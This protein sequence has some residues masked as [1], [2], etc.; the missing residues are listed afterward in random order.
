MRSRGTSKNACRG[1]TTGLPSARLA[2]IDSSQPTLSPGGGRA[3]YC[4]PLRQHWNSYT[5]CGAAE[6]FG[7]V[8][9]RVMSCWVERSTQRVDRLCTNTRRSE[10]ERSTEDTCWLA[11]CCRPL[12]LLEWAM[13]A[14]KAAPVKAGLA[15]SWRA[16]LMCRPP[17]CSISVGVCC[18]SATSSTMSSSAGQPSHSAHSSGTRGCTKVMSVVSILPSSLLLLLLPPLLWPLPPPS[19]PPPMECR[20]AVWG[21]TRRPNASSTTSRPAARAS[22]TALAA[23][24]VCCACCAWPHS[25]DSTRTTAVRWF[26][27]RGALLVEQRSSHRQLISHCTSGVSAAP[28]A[29]SSLPLWAA[30]PPASAPLAQA[31]T[32]NANGARSSFRRVNKQL[33]RTRRVAFATGIKGTGLSCASWLGDSPSR[34]RWSKMTQ[35]A[36]SMVSGPAVSLL[37]APVAGHEAS[38]SSPSSAPRVFKCSMTT[39]N[40]GGDLS[41]IA[42]VADVGRPSHTPPLPPPS[43]QVGC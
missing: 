32:S 25:A 31:G 37:L 27:L 22:A 1:S 29:R 21:G 35:K 43:E 33:Q 41:R 9:W 36:C 26:T 28:S 24:A 15:R 18:M 13:T 30:S 34:A 2:T 23:A 11:I 20:T 6:A 17:I 39:A 16:M 14:E 5:A 3:T 8:A 19:P 42:E 10:R 4:F 38:V 7:S 12:T 40:G